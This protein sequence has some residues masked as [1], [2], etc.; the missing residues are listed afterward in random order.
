MQGVEVD[1]VQQHLLLFAAHLL[2]LEQLGEGL[3]EG[4]GAGAGVLLEGELDFTVQVPR[5]CLL[6]KP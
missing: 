5:R 3:V 2:G 1:V 6:V 4:E